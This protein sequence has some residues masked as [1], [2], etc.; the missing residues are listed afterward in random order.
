MY[1]NRSAHG[2]Y[3]PSFESDACGVG[4]I[5][6]FKG[7]RTHQIVQDGLTILR[8][9]DHRGGCGCD[10]DTGD[11]AGILVHV[12]DAFMRDA[13][14]A[15]GVKLP[16]AG[17]YA[18]GMAF[19]PLADKL[20]AQCRPLVEWVVR[21][22]GQRFLGW[23]RVPTNNEGVGVSARA[24]E[25]SVW[26]F[27]V[28][29]GQTLMDAKAFE[30][31]LYVIRR[32]LEKAV[33]NTPLERDFYVCSLS[34]QT[35]V[36]K[37]MLTTH[38]LGS[39]YPDLNDPSFAS[40]LAMVHSRFSTNT[41]PLWKLAHPFRY[42]CHNGEINT[43]RGNVNWMR[44]R[45]G[46]FR[47]ERFGTDMQK[48]VPILQEGSSDSATLDQALELLRFTGRS[49]P[50]AMM[51]VVP[52]AWQ[53]HTEM[54]PRKKAFYEYHACIME[55]W[56]G[57]A[58]IPFT[59]GRYIGA[60]LDR[61]GLRPSRYT[62]TRSG[63][64]ILASETGVLNVDPAD[65]V[66]KGRLRPGR[67]LLAD[68]A[69]QRIISD[70]EV[71]QR[72]SQRNPYRFW[73]DHNLQ[74]LE[75]L[76]DGMIP[77]RI[78]GA[79]LLKLQQ[80]FDY[81]LEDLNII[82]A[83][84][85]AEGKEAVGSMGDD[86]P[87]AVLSQQRRLLYDY[88]KQLFAQV[89]NPPLDAIRE[90]L[91]TSIR[92]YLGPEGNLFHESP[93]NCRRIKLKQPIL[94]ERELSK[95]ATLDNATFRTKTLPMLYPVSEGGEALEVGL[96]QLCDSAI[97][98]VKSGYNILVLSDRGVNEALAGIPALLAIGAVHQHLTKLHKRTQIGLVIESAE[99]REVHHFA[100]LLGF[101]A[102]A[103]CPYGAL[104]TVRQLVDDGVI[105]GA[106]R[107]RAVK[108]YVKAVGK[109]L[110]K[111]MSKMG[112]STLSSYRG[113]QIFEALG[114]HQEVVEAYFTGTP[115][116]L[117][118]LKLAQLADE[119][120][121]RHARA[122]PPVEVPTA[123][124]LDVGGQYQ[125]RRGG[126]YHQFGPLSVAKLQQA[127]RQKD[128]GSYATFAQEIN[129]QNQ[130]LGTLRGLLDFKRTRQPVP[131]DEV[132]PWTAIAQR[133]KS[134]AMSYGSISQEAHETLAEAMNTI[135]G[136]SN[137]GEGGEQPERYQSTSPRRSRIKQ[138]ASGRF[139]VTLPYLV[140]ADEIQIKMAQGA[141]PGEGGQLP[142][143]KVYPWIAK[144]R[145]STPYV[146][147]ISPPPHHD[148]YS[149]EDLAQL[150]H[151]LKNTNPEARISVK[152]VSEV[153]VGTVAAGVTK[154]KADVVLISGSDGGTG[155]AAQTSIKHA[156]LPWELGL[157]EAHQTL[158][159]NGLRSRIVVEV[160]GQLK[161]GRDVA[162]A[163]LL[164]G[165]EFGF[166]TAPLVARGCIMMRKC[167]LNTCPVGVATQDP[168]LREKFVGLPEHVVNYFY[169]VANELRQIMA[170]LG[171]RT[172]DE[173][174]G[175][176]DQLAMRDASGYW[177][178]QHLDLSLILEQVEVPAY[179]TSFQVDTQD[180]GLDRALDHDLIAQAEPALASGERVVIRTSVSNVNR[181]VGT[182]LSAAVIKR[183]GNAGLH[184]DTIVV[185]ATGS[186]GQSFGAFGAPG[187]SFYIEGDAND[188]VGKGLSGA[189]ISLRP[190]AASTFLAEDNIIMGN[191]ALYGA[192]AGEL[193]VRGIAGERFAVR[194]SGARAVV[195][196]VGDHGC[197]Y[198]T[199]GRVVVLGGTG[200]NFAAGM[201]GGIAYVFDPSGAFAQQR[202]NTEMVE[203]SGLTHEDEDEV[204]QLVQNHLQATGSEVAAWVL[205]RW[206]EQAQHFVKVMPTEY[207]KALERMAAKR[208]RV[209]TKKVVEPATV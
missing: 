143:E 30:R 136:R 123:L 43:L 122:Y 41:F 192:T 65:I 20:A 3:D 81:T 37:G 154:A 115:S 208:A 95:I 157:A 182:M 171:F 96:K 57:P 133:F 147:L 13:C 23:R 101:G 88:F 152:L 44:A 201:S 126:E 48:V 153:G 138:V 86:T 52:E 150:I 73:L 158:L 31:K 83:P 175:R 113:A 106:D 179:L 163:A 11:G 186:A 1:Y 7:E 174:V 91:V 76:A 165:E 93:R 191:A 120:A 74:A 183:C 40:G 59:D 187:V 9:L 35:I 195:E 100:L 104:A 124:P 169:F 140:S 89:T 12:P 146:G 77:P 145:H 148:I 121:M 112:I 196:G 71:K 46:S 68:L 204:Q 181:T 98:A 135:G 103:I 67:M 87:Q 60:V 32:V 127:V 130:R 54:D 199:G 206:A 173:M 82:L 128:Q 14:A 62:I 197:E 189:T 193:Y 45:E 205:D 184:K 198:M 109:G 17:A 116:R 64:L 26:Q 166:A 194:N 190:P 172:V 80:A 90:E 75:G 84:M 119:V 38:Q 139:G 177:K 58:T 168:H 25:P 162:I 125:W 185:E 66:E 180:H 51:M 137:T 22:E 79:E 114:L 144:T 56:D 78:K 149:I 85:G 200:R 53:H 97:E 107:T 33:R 178:A 39:Y 134:G 70:D 167:H 16:E 4:M 24:M 50:H 18:V 47:S 99:P 2:L 105:A 42:I 176:V 15:E 203:L 170:D 132:E 117:S 161:T 69:E 202:C 110:L 151:D 142:G 55:P 164:G 29:P 10:E 28:A 209:V 118:G 111:V 34:T 131:L 19:L 108:H 63:L 92:T 21:D 36:Y 156:G 141:K 102:A 8:N 5:A 159:R 6:H 61:N 155:A 188:Y 207:R 27:F 129:D 160:D 49:L 94:T 72:I